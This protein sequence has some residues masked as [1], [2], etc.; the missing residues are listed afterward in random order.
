MLVSTTAVYGAVRRGS[1]V[2]IKLSSGEMV[3]GEVVAETGKGFIV[4]NGEK[5]VLVLFTDIATIDELASISGS[6]PAALSPVTRSPAV[7][8]A[9]VPLPADEVPPPLIARPLE[10]LST[11]E[12]APRAV[13]RSSLLE[14]SLRVGVVFTSMISPYSILRTRTSIAPYVGVDAGI[15]WKHFRISAFLQGAFL[16]GPPTYYA[17]GLTEEGYTNYNVIGFGLTPHF[18]FDPIESL[19]L[20]V[21]LPLGVNLVFGNVVIKRTGFSVSGG[22]FNAGAS[23]EASW[24]VTRQ[25]SIVGVFSFFSQPFGFAALSDGRSLGMAFPPFVF[26]AAG[27]ELVL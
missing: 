5:S 18:R 3:V 14:A 25:V 26:V 4:L 10:P 17:T 21:G 11:R 1:T 27:P 15:A 23:F 19:S 12:Q 9:P 13:R 8:P 20:R 2:R 22:G 24:R 16:S 7:G 6:R